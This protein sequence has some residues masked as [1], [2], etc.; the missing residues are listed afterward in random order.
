MTDETTPLSSGIRSRGRGRARGGSATAPAPN[1]SAK[2]GAEPQAPAHRRGHRGGRSHA[3]KESLDAGK[4][5]GQSASAAT[6]LDPALAV[7]TLQEMFPEWST[8]DLREVINESHGDIEVAA[9]R[10][11]EGRS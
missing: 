4:V 7:S 6:T 9:T 3:A 10:I 1:G 11:T 8:D 2:D 5:N